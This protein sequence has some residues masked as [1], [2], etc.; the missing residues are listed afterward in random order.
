M[1]ILFFVLQKRTEKR[2][3]KKKKK[4]KKTVTDLTSKYISALNLSLIKPINLRAYYVVPPGVRQNVTLKRAGGAVELIS[5]DNPY[6][7]DSP[8]VHR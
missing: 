7:Y 4:K 3:K 2:L 6:N 5:D 8:Q 1:F